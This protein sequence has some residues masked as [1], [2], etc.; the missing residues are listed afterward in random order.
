MGKIRRQCR[1]RRSLKKFVSDAI[2][3]ASTD[4]Y[5]SIAFPAVGCDQ[6]G[7]SANLVA[8]AMVEEAKRQISIRSV[9]VLFVI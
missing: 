9:S 4:G 6:I 5:K 7:C 2:E 1:T 3:K 8:Q